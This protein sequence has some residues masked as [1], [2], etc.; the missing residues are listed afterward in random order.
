MLP[1]QL[2]FANQNSVEKGEG[3]A[4]DAAQAAPVK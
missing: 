4:I 1:Q 3:R 2:I